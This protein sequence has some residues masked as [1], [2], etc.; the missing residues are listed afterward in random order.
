[1]GGGLKPCQQILDEGGRMENA[2]AY[3][4]TG[5]IMAVKVDAQD[6]DMPRLFFLHL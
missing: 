1:M 5:L 6:V 4:N 2:L 3:I